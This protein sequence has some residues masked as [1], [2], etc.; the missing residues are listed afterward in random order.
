ME[1][2]SSP[3]PEYG[4]LPQSSVNPLHQSHE[5]EKT[6]YTTQPAHPANVQGVIAPNVVTAA[7]AYP[8]QRGQ[9]T[10]VG[11]NQQDQ[12]SSS[13]PPPRGYWGSHICDW[14]RNVFPSCYCAFC[15]MHGCWIVGQ[16]SEKTGFSRFQT[17][18]AGYV[19]MW[20]LTLVIMFAGKL[21]NTGVW[22]PPLF[23][24]LVNIGL[25]LHIV[26]TRQITECGTPADS[27]R[28]LTG[29][30]C[31]ALWCGPCS[32]A[33]QARYVYGYNKIFDGDARVDRPDQYTQVPTPVQSV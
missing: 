2:H 1:L 20:V 5:L 26:R 17:V 31:C 9:R 13:R 21:E 23:M 4:K 28:N 14:P 16:M 11:G 12:I 15:C 25:R 29:E 22:L 3:I 32:I 24:M 33:Q 6:A 8:Q 10:T 19:V 27:C 7:S 18:T 30:C